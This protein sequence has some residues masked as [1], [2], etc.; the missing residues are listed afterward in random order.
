MSPWILLALFILAMAILIWR[1]PKIEQRPPTFIEQMEILNGQFIE[2]RDQILI[3]VVPVFERA[4]AQMQQ[5][6]E[7]LAASS[8]RR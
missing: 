3:E 1:A 7:V 5:F 6:A 4:A 2:L 8:R